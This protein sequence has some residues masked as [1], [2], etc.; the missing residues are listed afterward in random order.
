V[1]V[2]FIGTIGLIVRDPRAGRRFFV[3]AVGLPLQRPKGHDFLF[4][5]RLGG[6]RY[7]GVWSLSSAAQTCFGVKRWPAGRPVPQAFLEFEVSSPARVAAAAR[8]LAAKGYSLVHPPRTDAWGQTVARWQ[9]D[10]GLLV[11]ISHVPWMHRR[12]RRRR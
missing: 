12:P 7:F 3:G 8:E 6:S 1:K 4:T 5:R 10:D 9:T 11:A 2:R